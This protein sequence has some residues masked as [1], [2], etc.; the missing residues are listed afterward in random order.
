MPQHTDNN[1]RLVSLFLLGAV[2]FNYPLLS[3]FNH[4]SYMLGFPVLYLY[5]FSLWLLLIVLMIIITTRNRF[6]AKRRSPT[7]TA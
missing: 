1:K 7:E 5:I 4:K 2:F 3:I 6:R